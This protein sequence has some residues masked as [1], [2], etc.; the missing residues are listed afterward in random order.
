M[1]LVISVA[2][3]IPEQTK[4]GGGGEG[5]GGGRGGGN[6]VGCCPARES[7]LQLYS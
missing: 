2:S 1:A 3:Y 6:W 5:G 4:G 7:I